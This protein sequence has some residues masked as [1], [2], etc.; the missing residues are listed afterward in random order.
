MELE[1]RFL[2]VRLGEMVFAHHWKNGTGDFRVA[3]HFLKLNTVH[4]KISG[5]LGAGRG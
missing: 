5:L 1:Q 2:G 4:W 3:H